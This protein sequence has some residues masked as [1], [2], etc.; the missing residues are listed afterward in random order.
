M[1]LQESDQMGKVEASAAALLSEC[2]AVLIR[3]LVASTTPHPL[4][5]ANLKST[6][7]KDDTFQ[8]FRSALDDFQP[9]QLSA[10][11]L[12]AHLKRQGRVAATN[13]KKRPAPAKRKN[14]PS[15]ASTRQ[16]SAPAAASQQKIIAVKAMED[17]DQE[18]A[19]RIEE[20]STN[21]GQEVI[22]DEED[23]D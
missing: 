14:P 6:I 1:K 23:Y 3:K 7:E 8:C 21:R 13:N 11:F 19:A 12:S 2:S 10:S 18:F 16:K 20:T 9:V 4:T 5:I 22:E 17:V 15:T